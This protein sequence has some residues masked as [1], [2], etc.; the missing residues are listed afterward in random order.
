MQLSVAIRVHGAAPFL[1][2]AIESVLSQKCSTEFDLWLVLDRVDSA[3]LAQLQNV[4][5]SRLKFFEP[6]TCGYSSPLN[7]LLMAIESEYVAI[8]DS[9]DLMVDNR[10]ELQLQH[11]QSNPQIAVVGSSILLIDEIGNVSGK[12]EFQTDYKDIKARRFELL[13]LAHP[14]VLYVRSRVLEV[15]GYRD[16]YDYAED[17]DLW[18]RILEKFEIANIPLFL[19]KYRIHSQ[20]T[21]SRHIG[22][23]VL[24]GV[25]SRVSGERRS[26]GKSDFSELYDNVYRL[27]L[28]PRIFLEV[29]YRTLRRLAW[30]KATQARNNRKKVKMTFAVLLLL[31]V[32]FKGV[33]KKWRNYK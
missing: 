10:L 18:L 16:F 5:D 11:L 24:A 12:K 28:N 33:V 27:L 2:E 4:E 3:T 13:P 29:A 21:N 23:N 20:Q 22:R 9:D 14:A 19:T 26:Q 15:G 7:E 6:K 17:Y 31:L 32:D 8:L 1:L 25:A 30:L